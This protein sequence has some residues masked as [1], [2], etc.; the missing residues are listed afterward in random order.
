MTPCSLV[1]VL[2]AFHSPMFCS[3]VQ[4]GGKG[5]GDPVTFDNAY[6]SSLLK[7]P[8]ENKGDSMAAMIGL[9][10]DHV[11][12]DDPTCRPIIERYAADQS[13]FHADFAQAYVKLTSLG[14]QWA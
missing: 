9:P 1:C 5:F 12:P 2:H 8:W 14:A 11:L 6:Y 3:A 4:L 13:A 10:S 7:K